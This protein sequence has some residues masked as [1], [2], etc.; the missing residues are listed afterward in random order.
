MLLLQVLLLLVQ[1]LRDRVLVRRLAPRV[2]HTAPMVVVMMMV[3]MAGPSSTARC[4]RSRAGGRRGM[5]PP[6]G[7]ALPP[8]RTAAR[9]TALHYR[10]AFDAPRRHRFR[11]ERGR[12]TTAAGPHHEIVI[13]VRIVRMG[14]A[15]RVDRAAKVDRV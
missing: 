14:T 4:D 11:A 3:M 2:A 15:Y 1:Q 5:A 7:S 6:A 9:R 10:A 12:C 8:D 13:V